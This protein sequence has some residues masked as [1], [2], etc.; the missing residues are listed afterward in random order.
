MIRVYVE[1]PIGSGKTFLIR[2]LTS[3]L[4]TFYPL[5]ERRV[6]F[7]ERQRPLNSYAPFPTNPFLGGGAAG[8]GGAAFGGAMPQSASASATNPNEFFLVW[9]AGGDAPV[10][11]QPDMVTACLEAERLSKKHPGVEFYTLRAVRKSV[12]PLGATTTSTL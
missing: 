3:L 6:A 9:R 10:K 7:F 8:L 12:T 1:G 2:T 4:R 11:Q 5:L